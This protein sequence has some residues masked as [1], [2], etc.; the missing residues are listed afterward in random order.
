MN[1]AI[2]TILFEKLNILFNF[3]DQSIKGTFVLDYFNK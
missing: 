3:L 1:L 2:D